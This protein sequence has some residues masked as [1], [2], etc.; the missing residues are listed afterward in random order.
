MLHQ[1]CG[2]HTQRYLG[3]AGQVVLNYICEFVSILLLCLV[4]VEHAR[5]VLLVIL[6][7]GLQVGQIGEDFADG[8]E[9]RFY[10]EVDE[11][12]LAL[13]HVRGRPVVELADGELVRLLQVA[14]LEEL[15]EDEVGPEAA[16]MPGFGR[17]G[18]V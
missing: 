1:A 9:A 13:R 11:A 5:P 18:D 6:E 14:L 17:V 15:H 16:Q 3:L 8:D 10:Y 4:L 2:S 7:L 12:D